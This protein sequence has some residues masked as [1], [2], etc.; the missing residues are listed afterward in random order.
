MN[1]EISVEIP[2]QGI[3]SGVFPRPPLFDRCVNW[4]LRNITSLF[5][6]VCRCVGNA[7]QSLTQGRASEWG[8]YESL[9]RNRAKKTAIIKLIAFSVFGIGSALLVV[10]P[11]LAWI[12]LLSFRE[13]YRQVCILRGLPVLSPSTDSLGYEKRLSL[14]PHGTWH[15][16]D[17]AK[18]LDDAKETAALRLE[19]IKRAQHEVIISGNYFGGTH[20][21]EMCSTFDERMGQCHALRVYLILNDRNM[22]DDS[23]C[24]NWKELEALVRKYPD[25]FTVVLT[26]EAV[27]ASSDGK[28]YRYMSNHVKVTIVDREEMIFG[29]SCPSDRWALFNGTSA[30]VDDLGDTNGCFD[31]MSHVAAGFQDKDCY[32]CDAAQAGYVQRVRAGLFALL[33]RF[34]YYDR[35]SLSGDN[36]WKALELAREQGYCQQPIA[37]RTRIVREISSGLRDFCHDIPAGQGGNA[38]TVPGVVPGAKIMSLFDGPESPASCLEEEMV[39]RIQEAT[40]SITVNNMYFHPSTRVLEALQNALK[41][42]VEVT[43][44]HNR[45]GNGVPL[46]H[47]GFV[48]RSEWNI[49]RMADF[50][51]W[52][53]LHVYEWEPA[54]TTN[55]SKTMVIDRQHLFIGSSNYGY[56]GLILPS[57]YEYNACIDSAQ[58]SEQMETSNNKDILLCKEL[59][60]DSSPSCSDLIFTALHRLFQKRIG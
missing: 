12:P 7:P 36:R 49:R 3:I 47:R 60:L 34:D 18:I 51:S 28:D 41:R 26:P 40:S 31:V 45:S 23:R 35:H 43:I 16:V 9:D 56:K 29:G 44:I 46:V 50:H 2:L 14:A 8:S 22:R 1:S 10:I 59:D 5:Q 19:C 39:R 6:R 38:S 13:A 52:K 58:L 25:R 55:H 4:S 20:F 48:P 15:T 11:L 53:N 33:S 30:I 32:I 17:S 42:G 57:D 54:W 27:Q 21:S 24:D 37:Q